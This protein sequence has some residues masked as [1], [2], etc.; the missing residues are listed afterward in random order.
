MSSTNAQ[1]P[2]EAQMGTPEAE[3]EMA[4]YQKAQQQ[5]TA[6]ADQPET[7]APETVAEPPP[8]EMPTRDMNQT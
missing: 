8:S 4:A 7:E 6:A 1:E 5:A 2:S 3:P